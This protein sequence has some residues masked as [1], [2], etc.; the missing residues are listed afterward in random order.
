MTV[1]AAG[2]WHSLARKNDG[3]ARAWGYNHYGQLG[4]GTYTNSNTPVV[5]SSLT[6]LT[7]VA[8][9]AAG[10]SHS[11]AIKSGGTAWSWGYNSDGQLGIGSTTASN[12]PIQVAILTGVTAIE[13]GDGHSLA[14]ISGL[15]PGETAPGGT[16][17]SAQTWSGKDTLTWPADTNADS[18]RVYRGRKADLPHLANGSVD[19]CTR[20]EG[21]GTS[22]TIGDEPPSLAPGD[23]YWYLVVGL[24][25]VGEGSAGS[26]TS[27][28]RV[29]NSSGACL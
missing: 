22:A 26:A 21:P 11:L 10:D 23:F 12:Y 20:Y 3:T 1:I 2:G 8:A 14:L 4:N 6:G 13:G 17:G 29:V 15:T 9:I 28:G 7:G 18:Y 19:S 5:V 16:S 25:A 27:G 24:N